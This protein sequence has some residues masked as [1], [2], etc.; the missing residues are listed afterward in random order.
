MTH[1]KKTFYPEMISHLQPDDYFLRVSR[2]GSII[3][4][5]NVDTV[6]ETPI[7]RLAMY[8]NCPIS[9]NREIQFLSA[10]TWN[11][12]ISA[13]FSDWQEEGL[14]NELSVQLNI[15]KHARFKGLA[16]ASLEVVDFAN[17]SLEVC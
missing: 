8:S 11:E 2:D 5:I 10:K 12:T 16:F 1:A 14:L 4:Y 15:N 13:V 17:L 9:K 3:D 7:K 6:K